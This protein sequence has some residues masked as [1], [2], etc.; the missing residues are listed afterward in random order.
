MKRKYSFY[1]FMSYF[2]IAELSKGG[3][4]EISLNFLFLEFWMCLAIVFT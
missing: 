4:G 2:T 1:S 3:G